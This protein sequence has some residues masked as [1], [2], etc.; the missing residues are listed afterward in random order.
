[1][2][3]LGEQIRRDIG[4]V[5]AV[6]AQDH[7]LAGAGEKIDGN[8]AENLALGFDDVFVSRAENF[9]HG[10]DRLRPISQRADG[11]G[12][13]ESVN[14]RDTRQVQRHEHVR[15]DFSIGTAGGGNDDFFAARR[16]R[17][18]CRHQHGT[19]QR[20]SAAGD[21]QAD[22][23][24]RA[25]NFSHHRPLRILHLPILTQ[26]AAGEFAHVGMGGGERVQNVRSHTITR[27]GNFL[28]A[29]AQPD[30]PQIHAIIFQRHGLQRGIAMLPDLGKDA[31][32]G[33]FHAG[34][35][36]EAAVEFGDS[37]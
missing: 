27:G 12:S 22:A 20:G 6:I 9:L 8:R 36:G 1:M 7:D 33:G 10:P 2:L 3:G 18:R 34:S 21:I 26:A 25:E 23:L 31:G 35:G 19:D 4:G 17:Q 16:L 15:V 14:F 11:L 32:H 29:D 24:K 5:R 37:R 30:F 13:A 28:L